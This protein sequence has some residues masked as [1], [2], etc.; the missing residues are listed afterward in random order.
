MKRRQDISATVA[1]LERMAARSG[2][3]SSLGYEAV[4]DRGRRQAARTD[5]RS[6]DHILPSGK[7][8]K[9]VATARD[10]VRNYVTAGWMVRCHLDYVARFEFQSRT[11]DDALDEAVEAFIE[12]V[13]R[14]G[15]FEV[16]GRHSLD[17][18]L[19]MQEAR[20]VLDG[21]IFIQKLA[22][23]MVQFIE[24]DRVR[25]PEGGLPAGEVQEGDGIVQGVLVNPAGRMKAIAVCKRNTGGGYTLDRVIPARNVW[26]QAYWDTTYRVDQVR[27][28]SPLAPGLNSI[29]DIY[30]GIDLAMAKAKVAQMFGLVFYRQKVEEQE[31]WAKRAAQVDAEADTEEGDVEGGEAAASVE[32]DERYDVDP[33]SGPFKLELDDNDRAEFLSTNTPEQELV[34]FLMFVTDLALKCLDIPYSFYDPS[35]ANYYNKKADI[36]QYENSA[37]SKREQNRCWLNEWT[38]WRLLG[39]ILSGELVLPAGKTIH[40]L[41]WDWVPTGMPWVDKLRDMKADTMAMEANLD[42]EIRIARRSGEDVYEIA[43]ERLDFEK[44]YADER[45]KRKLPPK[46]A[47]GSPA[48]GNGDGA[49]D[50]ADDADGK[51]KAKKKSGNITDTEDEGDDDA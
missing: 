21:D 50:E 47:K 39:A 18:G 12:K 1:A 29:Q 49:G 2:R 31:G 34:N 40:D 16:T 10:V 23:G 35:K 15:N 43:R 17:M 22:S 20:K 8:K 38:F 7:R 44:W 14:R 13:G 36:Q 5:L 41:S 37:R 9:M 28:V 30:E 46:A 4:E 48:D 26:Q 51:K 33:G 24:G 3:S 32:D 19:R 25:T 42:S 6:E 11:G 27:G 45:A